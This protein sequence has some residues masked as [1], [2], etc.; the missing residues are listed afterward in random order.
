ML[1]YVAEITKKHFFDFEVPQNLGVFGGNFEGFKSKLEFI[2][3]T[4]HLK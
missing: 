3:P 2:L 1:M 4:Y